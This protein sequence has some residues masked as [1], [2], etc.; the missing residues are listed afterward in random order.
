[1]SEVT[2]EKGRF[3]HAIKIAESIVSKNSPHP[4]LQCVLIEWDSER[5][6][7]SSRGDAGN[8]TAFCP[9]ISS[10]GSGRILIH[11]T[12]LGQ[13]VAA[14]RSDRVSLSED[15]EKLVVKSGGQA[16][17][18]TLD[19]DTFPKVP[20]CSED[21]TPVPGDEF[22]TAIKKSVTLTTDAF[23]V[24]RIP[25]V[26]LDWRDGLYCVASC[27]NCI[28]IVGPLHAEKRG[29]RAMITCDS[30]KI[31]TQTEGDV[32]VCI[33][34]NRVCFT[35]DNLQLIAPIAA[36][37]FNRYATVP[38][39]YDNTKAT[40]PVGALLAACRQVA[41]VTDV[42]C[43]HARLEVANGEL[44]VSSTKSQ[45]GS[46]NAPVRCEHTGEDWT[47]VNNKY[48][49]AFLSLQDD[50]E[51]VELCIQ[52]SNNATFRMNCGNHVYLLS[53]ITVEG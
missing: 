12:R 17:F 23:G 18:N 49:L 38:D 46:A 33:E 44:T 48:P 32:G 41:A 1:M 20:D 26:Y 4:S 47:L 37:K 25:V 11:P 31:L 29:V 34:E 15:G 39:A 52:D 51:N 30:A 22:R 28:S 6:S 13:F 21:C 27:E 19:P 8:L 53:P 16:V 35:A 43:C 2:L 42:E 50:D 3:G 10:V 14:S 40:M 24:R 7:I 45:Y 9:V 5:M 36:W